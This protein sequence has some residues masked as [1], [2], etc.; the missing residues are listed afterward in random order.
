MLNLDASGKIELSLSQ[1][2]QADTKLEE[3]V[4]L[5]SLWIEVS[6][7]PFIILIWIGTLTVVLGFLISV[8]RRTKEANK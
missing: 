6:I 3:D 5:G 2:D 8:I 7:K 1:I 4:A